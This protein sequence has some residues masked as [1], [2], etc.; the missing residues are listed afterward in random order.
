MPERFQRSNK[1]QKT[2]HSSKEIQCN[3]CNK[4]VPSKF[5]YVQHQAIHKQEKKF[6]NICNKAFE[7]TATFN[8]HIK[9]NHEMNKFQCDKCEKDFTSQRLLKEHVTPCCGDHS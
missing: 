1:S 5:D 4:I 6:C 7:T 8:L 3:I 2:F 9:W